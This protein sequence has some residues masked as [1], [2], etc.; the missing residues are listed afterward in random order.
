MQMTPEG[1]V[2]GT[3]GSFGNRD[4][5]WRWSLQRRT[6]SWGHLSRRLSV[7]WKRVNILMKVNF[8]P[9]Q[10]DNGHLI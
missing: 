1:D 7:A 8:W 9:L 2:F 10:A 4:G 3:G 6:G 5:S